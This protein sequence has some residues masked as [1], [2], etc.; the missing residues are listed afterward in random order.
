[1]GYR[2]CIPGGD[3]TQF[4]IIHTEMNQPGFFMDNNNL[5][6][7]GTVGITIMS[8]CG[9]HCVQQKFFGSKY[10]WWDY[11]VELHKECNNIEM[12]FQPLPLADMDNHMIP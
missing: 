10:L 12:A 4:P 11:G 3:G 7:I 2:K 8:V 1:M 6:C 5:R 9:S